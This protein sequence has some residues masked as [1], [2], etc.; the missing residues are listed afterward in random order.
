MNKNIIKPIKISSHIDI[1]VLENPVPAGFPS[2]VQ[3][4]PSDSI[5]L[6]RELI[7]HPSSTF[8]ARVSGN[9]MIECGISDGDLLIIDKSLSPANGSVSVCFID[10]EFTLKK[11]SL[12]NDGLYLVPANRKYAE[13]KVSE[14]S[15]FQVWGIVTHVIKSIK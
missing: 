1:P 5:D 11:I 9:S 10:G 7:D 3:G 13:I 2:P 6:N 4:L 14:E 12:R 15:N 8:C